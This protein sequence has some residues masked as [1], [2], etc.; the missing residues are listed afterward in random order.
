MIALPVVFA[1]NS[2]CGSAV[3]ADSCYFKSKLGLVF[4]LYGYIFEVWRKLM[5]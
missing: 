3:V 5:S 4:D 1:P 2:Q